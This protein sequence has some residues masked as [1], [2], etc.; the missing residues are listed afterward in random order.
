MIYNVQNPFFMLQPRA[1]I[2]HDFSRLLA[3]SQ[4]STQAFS[5]RLRILPALAR[6]TPD[7]IKAFI[8]SH[9]LTP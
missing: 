6:I 2:S 3:M 5:C 1:G 8:S 4:I 7:L 9:A